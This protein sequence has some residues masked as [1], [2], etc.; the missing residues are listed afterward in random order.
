[1]YSSRLSRIGCQK[2][3]IFETFSNFMYTMF[4]AALPIYLCTHASWTATSSLKQF[5]NIH[6]GNTAQSNEKNHKSR[7]FW[8]SDK[9]YGGFLPAGNSKFTSYYP[10][11]HKVSEKGSRSGAYHPLWS[12]SKMTSAR[13][14]VGLEP[15]IPFGAVQK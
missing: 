1:M 8:H 11:S 6:V 13:R 12:R 2:L 5:Q 4:L 14:V 7:F 3:P 9:E 15:T 10:S